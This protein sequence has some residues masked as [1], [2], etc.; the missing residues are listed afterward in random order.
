MKVTFYGTRGSCPISHPSK[1][2]Y[3]GNTTCL[4]IE[5]SSLPAG[6]W[7]VIDAGTGIVPLSG[8]FMQNNGQEVTILQTHY[9]HDHTQGLALS[10]FPYAKHIP[11][12]IYGPTDQSIG[13]HEVYQTL[14]RPPYFPV[15]FNEISSH[16]QCLTIAHPNSTVLILHSQGG[17]Q[18]LTVDAFERLVSSGAPIPFPQ[19]RS[20]TLAECL[21]IAMHRSNHPERTISYR[22][23]ERSTGQVFAFVTDH[24]N[25]D[26][27]P[28]SFAN[29]LRNVDLLVMDSQYTRKKYDEMTAGWGHGTPDYSARVAKM[30]GAKALGLTHHDPTSADALV[31]EIVE[32]ARALLTHDDIDIPV[33]GCRDY[34]TVDIGS[35]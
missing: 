8:D 34:Q 4:R 1:A 29:H 14:M 30:V 24:E 19:N 10:A 22:F 27:I 18:M 17:Q 28:R 21:V 9:H 2:A 16:I 5:S 6:H 33:F 26:G 31:E 23:E 25:Q 13:P 20:F 12:T 15:D 3:G 11:V 35:A 7:L 32:S